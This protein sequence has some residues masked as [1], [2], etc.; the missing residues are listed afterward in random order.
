MVQATSDPLF[1]T[2]RARSPRREVG[3]RIS[4]LVGLRGGIGPSGLGRVACFGVRR[5]ARHWSDPVLLTSHHVLHAHGSGPGDHVFAPE[6]TDDGDLLEIDP[7]S[8]ASV[9]EVTEDGLDGVHRHAFPGEPERDY[10]LDCATARLV[11]TEL[12]PTGSVAFRV[13]R[14]HQH[15]ALPQRRLGVR[16]L[17]IHTTSAGEVVDTHATVERADGVLCP[18]TIVVRSRPGA[19][20]FATD[21]DSGAL[22]VDRRDRAI[23]LLWG[24]DLVDRAIAYACHVLP[25]LDRLDVVPSLRLSAARPQTEER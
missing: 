22:V 13:G 20:P 15:D 6:V 23:G 11:D 21:G 19:P 8:L 17:G 18:G 16:L 9:A 7:A 2:M 3:A 12:V 5:G 24:V 4:T 1:G 10:H 14:V 25:V